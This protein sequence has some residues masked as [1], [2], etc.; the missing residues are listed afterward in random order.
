MIKVQGT[1]RA[2]A[3]VVT[4]VLL[5]GLLRPAMAADETIR[6]GAI[7]PLTGPGAVV[8]T[9]EM[10]GIQF[11]MDAANAK[12]GV[13]G[14]KIEVIF[15]DNQAKPD[16]SVLSFNKLVD[17][18][19][20][21]MIFTGYSGPSLA[22]APLATRKKILMINAG[23]QSDKL[24]K[25][26]PYLVNT[27]PSTGD[28]V[29]VMAKYLVQQGKKKAA[30]L[31]ENDAAGIGGRDDFLELFPK[32]GG[33]ILAQEAVQFGQTDYRPA[34]LKLA[35]AKPDVLYVV[36]TAGMVPLV[37][38]LKQMNPDFLVAGTTFM[39][40][41][42]AIADPASNGII[43]TQVQIDAPPELS[44]AFKAKYGDDM[45][46]FARQYYNAA[47]IMLTVIDK[48]LSEKKP[49]TGENLHDTLFAIRKF[50]GLIPMEF[51]SNTAT[52]PIGI[53]KMENGKDVTLLQVTAE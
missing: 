31:F 25:A 49:V 18:Q 52:V 41:P 9:Q 24:T 33:T 34:L 36:I 6:L 15:E 27:L 45:D 42:A 14:H 37:Q 38:Q 40:D 1:R 20:V 23:A 11:A 12:G 5:S 39:A 44:A 43:H 7:L 51:K 8:G 10:R 19:K 29:A 30:V 35:A 26:S 16:V 4:S 50:Q 3:A 2:F 53:N 32:A 28:E 48:V 47:Q 21:P 13:Q 46:F 17:L 22:M